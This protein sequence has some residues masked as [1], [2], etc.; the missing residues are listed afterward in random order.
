MSLLCIQEVAELKEEDLVSDTATNLVIPSPYT[1]DIADTINPHTTTTP[2]PVVSVSSP[3]ALS[4]LRPTAAA[5]VSGDL[6][7]TLGEIVM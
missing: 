1:G 2:G 3:A 6:S 5:G 4:L 7:K